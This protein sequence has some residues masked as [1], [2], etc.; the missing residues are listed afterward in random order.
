[1]TIPRSPIL[2]RAR[3]AAVLLGSASLSASA[4]LSL[5]DVEGSDRIGSITVS[6]TLTSQVPRRATPTA[7]F[8]TSQPTELPNSRVG[9]DQCGTFSFVPESFAPGNLL[10]GAALQLQV[11]SQSYS[12]SER[13]NVPRVYGLTG[14]ETFPYTAGDTLRVSIPGQAGGFPPAQIAVRLAEPVALAPLVVTEAD[15]DLAFQ[16][17]TNGDA[18]SSLIISMRYTTAVTTEVP[19]AQLLCIVRD[20]GA[21]TIPAGTLG[22]YYASN[23]ASRSVNVLRWRTNA[24]RVD[25]RSQLYIVST[26]DTS[27]TLPPVPSGPR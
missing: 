13:S 22:I 16:W 10:A 8:F 15:Q 25:D 6:S 5:G 14:G 27:F 12:M 9:S 20:N 21:Y 3:V 2:T 1:M 17:E 26:S 11:G 18:N 7:T 4:C 19:D 23:P 24:V